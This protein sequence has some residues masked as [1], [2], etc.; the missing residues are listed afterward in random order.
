MDTS[1]QSV[2]KEVGTTEQQ[3]LPTYSM[4]ALMPASPSHELKESLRQDSG[5]DLVYMVNHIYSSSG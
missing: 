3:D 4:C 1:G 2:H 5:K